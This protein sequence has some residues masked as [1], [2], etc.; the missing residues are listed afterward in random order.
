MEYSDKQIESLLSG[1]YSGIYTNAELPEDLYFAIANYLKKGV[2][3]GYG[4]ALADFSPLSRDYALLRE[5]RENIYIFSGAKTYQEVNVMSSFLTSN[6][7]VSS[8]KD[9]KEK[10]TE[11]YN[12]Y[13]KTWLQTEYN[14]AVGQA[15]MA[16]RWLQVEER[17]DILPYLTYDAVMDKN[18]SEICRGLDGITLPVNDPFWKKFSPLNHFNCRCVLRQSD[19]VKVSSKREVKEAR[20]VEEN[21]QP[22]F[23][24]NP[25]ADKVIFSDKHPYYDIAPKDKELA[26]NNFN[27]P[28]PSND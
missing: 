7:G 10:A 20:K 1:I 28:I 24:M 8:F 15:Q 13:N 23:V 17:S 9:F 11:V 26:K 21:M 6:G 4:G 12:T 27:L 5:L 18:T 14:T 19:D 25:G 3:S 2:Y 16:E 22:I